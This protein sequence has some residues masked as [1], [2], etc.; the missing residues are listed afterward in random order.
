MNNPL[1]LIALTLLW[2]ILLRHCFSSFIH[3]YTFIHHIF[4][5]VY[6]HIKVLTISVTPLQQLCYILTLASH[7]QFIIYL[8][9]PVSLPLPGFQLKPYLP[10]SLL[11]FIFFFQFFSWCFPQ[12][13]SALIL[14][15]PL[16]FS[17]LS[18]LP[19]SLSSSQLPVNVCVL[20]T[21]RQR[22]HITWQVG[23]LTL[24][25][26][27]WN[28]RCSQAN[29]PIVAGHATSAILITKVMSFNP[30][31]SIQKQW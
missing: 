26:T 25:C 31:N 3:F 24:S 10:P 1:N 6:H 18:S 17:S 12:S 7:L 5:T 9:I 11:T 29:P 28:L 4:F 20:S 19:P 21:V 27:S 30:T 8:F 23:R 15:T 16:F 2:S 14:T 22:H 13:S